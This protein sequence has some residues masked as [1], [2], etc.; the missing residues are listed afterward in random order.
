MGESFMNTDDQLI[1][2]FETHLLTEKRVAKNTFLAYQ[3]DIKQLVTFLREQQLTLFKA[4][5]THLK[6]FL[7]QLKQQKIKARTL[8]RKISA[9]KLLYSYL[10]EHFNVPNKAEALIFPKIEKTL[11]LYLTEEEIERLFRVANRFTSARGIRN[12]TMLSFLYATGMRITELLQLTIPQINFETGFVHVTGKGNKERS[13]PIQQAVLTL[14][15]NYLKNTY[16]LLLPRKTEQR[17]QQLF[18]TTYRND[19]KPMSRQSFWII[20]KKMLRQ[21]QITK[22]VS[23]H[24][25]R[26]SLA[27]HLLKNGA[28]LRSLQLLLGHEQLSTVQ[29][30]THLETSQIRKIY[31]EKHP[32]S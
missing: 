5:K 1:T 27:T 19:I 30:Y 25:L 20:L 24:T 32:R 7:K 26:H 23:P 6:R 15:G 17:S 16:K 13:I 3:R 4:T 12:K 10:N 9:I 31:D 14:L 18:F 21:A 8:S 2:A 22:N 11:P 28:N 29:I